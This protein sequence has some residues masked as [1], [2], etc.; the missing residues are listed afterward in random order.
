MSNTI[1]HKINLQHDSSAVWR[2]ISNKEHLA[3][4]LMENDF[5]L[6]VGRN[7][8]FWTK[9]KFPLGFD[10]RVY[11]KVIDFKENEFLKFAWKG[12]VGEK[13]NLDTMVTF[14]LK[15]L[16]NGCELNLEQTG[17]K[18]LK[19]SIPYF[20]MGKGWIKILRRL[21]TKLQEQKAN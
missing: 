15:S 3:Q 5:E 19:N 1:S 7:F 14:S 2:F 12:G 6:K 16:Q 17:F 8:Q 10:G 4:W 18:P 13:V 20:I 21:E 11:C 9:P